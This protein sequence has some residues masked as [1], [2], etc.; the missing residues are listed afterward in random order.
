MIENVGFFEG[1][2][3]QG[4][5]SFS[6]LLQSAHKNHEVIREKESMISA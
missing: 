2:G 5:D 1:K 4:L 6:H 3:V